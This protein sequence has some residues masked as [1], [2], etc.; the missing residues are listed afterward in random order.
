MTSA[1]IPQ[2]RDD[3]NSSGRLS[4]LVCPLWL[5]GRLRLRLTLIVSNGGLLLLCRRSA[6]GG[7]SSGG[8]R[9]GRSSSSFATFALG[10]G[11]LLIRFDKRSIRLFILDRCLLGGNTVL[12]RLLSLGRFFSFISVGFG[13]SFSTLL[14]LGSSLLG[15]GRLF[16]SLF[17][18][19]RLDFLLRL[20][21]S[22]LLGLGSG[23][24]SLGLLLGVLCLSFRAGLL[25]GLSASALLTL[26]SGL[27]GS[28][29]FRGFVLGRLAS[30]KQYSLNRRTYIILLSHTLPESRLSRPIE[31]DILGDK[32]DLHR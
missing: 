18:S 16:S 15:L 21:T 22:T 29:F 9:S 6:S 3:T 24:L 12:A 11:W 10:G 13:S 17:F 7:T 25:L 30:I 31:F 2:F 26:R 14:G 23:L 20:S 8:L 4:L 27:L 5:L 1:L 28:G 19:V 32:S